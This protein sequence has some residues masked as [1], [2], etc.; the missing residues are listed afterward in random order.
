[1]ITSRIAQPTINILNTM[2]RTSASPPRRITRGSLARFAYNATTASTVKIKHEEEE[3][4]DTEHT[5]PDLTKP[6]TKKRKRTIS[7]SKTST[8]TSKVE[9]DAVPI[10]PE[11]SSS[12]LSTPER[13]LRQ[14]RK[15]EEQSPDIEDIIPD[16]S[17][18]PQRTQ[19]RTTA[20]AS[21]T[22]VST[23]IP[24]PG[25]LDIKR[26]PTPRKPARKVTRP[27]GQ[28][29]ISPPPNWHEIYTLIR[30]MRA[31]GGS[32]SNAPVD[33][34]G[35]ERLALR[36]APPIVQRFQ[37]LVA[38]M[39]SS[40][41]KDTVNAVAMRRLQTELP[42]H[43]EGAEGG[44]TVDNVIAVAPEKLNELIY[45]VGFHNNKTKYIQAAAGICKER[46]GG[47]IPDTFSGL[48]SLPG[49]GPKMAHLCLAAAWGRVEGIG[50]DVHVHRITNLWG[51][52]GKG[53][54]NPEDT[55]LRLESWLPRE[56]W[57]EINTLLVGLGQT[58]CLPV[59]RRCGECEVGIRGLCRAA[60]RGKVNEGRRRRVVEEVV[61]GE[62][63]EELKMEVVDEK[64][65]LDEETKIEAVREDLWIGSY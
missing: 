55:R 8:S 37:T 36:S 24:T 7:T 40:Q 64:L 41:T 25:T 29:T 31:P 52:H 32:A 38:L 18:R 43:A 35:C 34:M 30:A 5:I 61:K 44:L 10:K 51:W 28:T 57:H 42:A 6:S 47:D 45:A 16:L 63:K 49:V 2:A 60:D 23:T 1:M 21:K 9:E 11:P 3:S 53:S 54:K 26:S 58:V 17:K 62:V 20:S 22:P 33:T 4:P 48:V 19:K 46:Y 65:E 50:V 27:S 59:G 14:R 15:A 13:P 39:L 12:P 56:M